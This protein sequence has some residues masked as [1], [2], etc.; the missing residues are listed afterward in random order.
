MMKQNIPGFYGVG[1][2][3]LALKKKGKEEELKKLYTNSLFFRTLI[4]NSMMSLTKTYYNATTYLAHDKEFGDF[5]KKM[6]REYSLSKDEVLNISGLSGLMENNPNIRDSVRLRERIVLPL[7]AI[8]QYALMNI[9]NQT[10][11]N[12][13]HETRYRR[14]IIRAMFGIINAARNSA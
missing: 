8:Q 14:L 4:G 1:S 11:E 12:R 5:W 2:A 7:I 9:R 10:E 6:F 3:L 13:M